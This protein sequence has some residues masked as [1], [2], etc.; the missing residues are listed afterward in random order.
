MSY[1]V[2]AALVTS[3][4]SLMSTGAFAHTMIKST[5]IAEGATLGASPPSVTVV[6]EHAAGIGSVRLTTVTGET[7][8]LTFTPPRTIVATFTIPL[9]R[10]DPDRYKLEWRAIAQD[11]H[12]MAGAINFAVTG[13]ARPMPTMAP[14]NAKR[15]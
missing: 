2:L 1:K 6:L 3:T 14:P 8:P 5:T 4:L 11:G 10:L 12:V 15:P 7:I 9:P 13:G